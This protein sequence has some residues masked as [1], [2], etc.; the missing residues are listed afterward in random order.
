[1]SFKEFKNSQT[2]EEL[3]TSYLSVLCS[4]ALT[5]PGI[6]LTKI[7]AFPCMYTCETAIFIRDQRKQSKLGKKKIFNSKTIGSMDPRAP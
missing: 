6:S 2:G 3:L 4:S 7:H 5:F 1:M